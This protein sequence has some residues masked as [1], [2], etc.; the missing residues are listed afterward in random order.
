MPRQPALGSA[1]L[2]QLIDA[3]VTGS[4][5]RKDKLAEVTIDFY[6]HAT[7]D[8]NTGALV[9]RYDVALPFDFEQSPVLSQSS[10]FSPAMYTPS[11]A[12]YVPI[13]HNFQFNT[14]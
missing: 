2:D 13:P 8:L 3:F 10:G 4:A 11:P 6:N 1:E 7:V 14:Y 9:R 12:R 5:A